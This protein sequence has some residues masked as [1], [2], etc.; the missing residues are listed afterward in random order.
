[1]QRICELLETIVPNTQEIEVRTRGNKLALEFS[2]QWGEK[3]PV[4]FEAFNMS[5]GTLRAVGLLA[6][7]YQSPEPTLL[8]IEEPEATIHVGAL[9]ALLD[10]LRHAA[11]QMQLVVTTHSPEILDASWIEDKHLRIVE[12]SEGTTRIA[13]LSE[14]T[15]QALSE[16]LMGA[17]E[18]LRA[19]ALE[20]VELFDSS[21][22]TDSLFE[23]LD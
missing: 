2:Q 20:A 13:P 3:K 15:R 10:L 17:G 18:L 5:D 22:A 19:N 7:V 16:H 21:V 1:M 9:G 8:A 11:R 4:R 14:A 6:A 12:W 23:V